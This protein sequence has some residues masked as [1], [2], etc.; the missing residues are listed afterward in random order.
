M[1][2]RFW[3]CSRWRSPP[4]R[5]WRP[6]IR[7]FAL[8]R[9]RPFWSLWERPLRTSIRS[10][11]RSIACSSR[12]RRFHR[13]RGLLAVL[14]ARAQVLLIEAAAEMLDRLAAALPELLAGFTRPLEAA[15]IRRLHNDIAATY[16]RAQEAGAEAEREQMTYLAAQPDPA[17]LLRTLL[18]LRHRSCLDRT[19]GGRTVS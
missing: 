4:W 10:A 1:S 15:E 13:P 12:A 17:P 7:I 14:P 18:R 6:L 16:A 19:G 5:C 3:P 2:S 11:R 9:S 8:H